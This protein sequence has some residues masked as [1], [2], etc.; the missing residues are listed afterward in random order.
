[1]TREEI[2]KI[3]T[4]EKRWYEIGYING[5]RDADAEPNLKSLW[6][7]NCNGEMAFIEN[8]GRILKTII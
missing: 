3:C 6:M 8:N 5:L 7:N 2:E 4:I 1:M